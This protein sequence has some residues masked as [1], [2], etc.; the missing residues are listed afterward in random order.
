[1]GECF[2]FRGQYTEQAVEPFKEWRLCLHFADCEYF[3][4]PECACESK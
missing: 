3:G 1:V 2:E 4:E